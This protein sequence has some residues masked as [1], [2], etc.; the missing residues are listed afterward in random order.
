MLLNPFVVTKESNM[1]TTVYLAFAALIGMMRGAAS[2]IIEHPLD[3]IKTYW[4]AYPSKKSV[5]FVA[6]EIRN[7]KGWGGFY[8]GAVPNIIRV[9]LKQAYRYPLMVALPAVFGMLTNSIT[10]ISISTGLSI[11]LLEVGII[12]PLE[13]LKV[14][15][16]TYQTSTGGIKVFLGALRY[17]ALHT[18]YKGLR[19]T[20]F[21]QI[22]SWGTFLVVHDQL[23]VWVKSYN[24]GVINLSL[25]LLLS[26]SLIEGTINTAVVQPLDCIKTN[27]QKAQI[28]GRDDIIKMTK[29]IYAVYGVRGFYVAWGVRMIQYM[30]NSA[31]TVAVLESLKT[32]FAS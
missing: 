22:V 14:W 28:N 7:L 1:D 32:G 24:G 30:I 31:F 9:M 11:A 23:M 10:L 13:R 12:T 20:A 15:L 19:I 2:L 29:E 25:L 5:V 18:L 4:Q 26:V 16:M 27:Q 8:S 21:R 17:D 3:V 6:K